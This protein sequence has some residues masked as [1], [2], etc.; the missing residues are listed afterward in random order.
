MD[1]FTRRIHIAAPPAAVFRALT[2]PA[3]LVVW[4]DEH[5]DVS[6]AEGRYDFWGRYSLAGERG[7]K[8]LLA[9]EPDRRLRFAWQ[10]G[11]EEMEQDFALQ[12]EGDAGTLLTLTNSNIPDRD[13]AEPAS[14]DF[15]AMA[16]D[17]LAD[18]AEERT[19]GGHI[20]LSTP[21]G[22][23]GWAGVQ[24]AATPAQVWAALTE[25]DQLNRW[26]A[27]DAK[28]DLQPGGRYDLGWDH[29]PVKILDLEPRRVLSYSW[30]WAA[31]K[32]T[33]VRWELE[34]SAGQTRVT[35]VHSGFADPKHAAGYRLGWQ[36]FLT[37]LKRML[38]GGATWRPQEMVEAAP[39]A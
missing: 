15:W 32:D 23:E 3:A 18:Y 22:Q 17:N 38:E 8:R 39:A 21:A 33:V 7:R 14:L 5:A 25:P 34:G 29:G 30:E 26:M 28:V 2:D 19:H 13:G 24:V 9:H 10:I 6:L 11:G 16:L 1:R 35:I 20:D 27:V 37:T 4:L 36:A 12:P 31:E